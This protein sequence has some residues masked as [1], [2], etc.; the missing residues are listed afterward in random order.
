MVTFAQTYEY[1]NESIFERQ[2]KYTKY[3][4]MMLRL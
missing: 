4:P 2:L 3:L 1:A